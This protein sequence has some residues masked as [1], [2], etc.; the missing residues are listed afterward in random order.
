MRGRDFHRAGAFFRIGIGVADDRDE[1]PRQ[2]QHDLAANEMAKFFVLGMDGHSRIAQH[3]LGTRG[4]D[5]DEGRSIL[6]VVDRALERIVEVPEMALGLDLLHLKI[7]D[8][9]QQL[10]VPVHKALVLV[11][12]TLAMKLDKDLQDGARQA[13]VHGE[14]LA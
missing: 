9:G 4:G 3:R 14:A 10:R 2:R 13:L 5:G 8:R 1:A 7:G 6:G 12:E 11:D